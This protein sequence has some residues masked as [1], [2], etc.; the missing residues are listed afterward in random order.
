MWD[1]NL[2]SVKKGDRVEVQTVID[3]PLA[4]GTIVSSES[5]RCQELESVLVRFDNGAFQY[6]PPSSVRVIG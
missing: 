1:K 2:L 4:Y 6:M 3:G 5:I